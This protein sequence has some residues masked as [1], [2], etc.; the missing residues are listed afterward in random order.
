MFLVLLVQGQSSWRS[1]F[2]L[3]PCVE[4]TLLFADNFRH[5]YFSS[6]DAVC[7]AVGGVL[8]EAAV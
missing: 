5:G 3:E 7:V 2:I 8:V 6:F 1:T 4:W